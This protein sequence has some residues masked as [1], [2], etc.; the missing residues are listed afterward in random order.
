MR[1]SRPRPTI[2][3]GM[4]AVAVVAFALSVWK[5]GQRPEKGFIVV[6]IT[7]NTTVPLEDIEVEFDTMMRKGQDRA[8]VGK[9][10]TDDVISPGGT[11]DL[12]S[13]FW[14][15]SSFK[16]TCSTPGRTKR[17]GQ[18]MVDTRNRLL[19]FYVEPTGVRAVVTNSVDP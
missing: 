9:I 3:S 1:I 13:E 7:N 14:G 4:I 2:A 8:I 11:T 5:N 10:V 19:R 17:T 15:D 16:F 6:R 12:D 18:A